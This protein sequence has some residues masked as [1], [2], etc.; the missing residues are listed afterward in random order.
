MINLVGHMPIALAQPVSPR[1]CL[2][3]RYMKYTLLSRIQIYGCFV[4]L[5]RLG[6]VLTASDLKY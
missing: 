3:C 5:L 6:N 4:G 2:S 1:A